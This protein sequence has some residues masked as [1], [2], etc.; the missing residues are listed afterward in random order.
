MTGAVPPLPHISSWPIQG[1]HS[2]I[3]FT[4]EVT[5]RLDSVFYSKETENLPRS[6]IVHNVLLLGQLGIE[7]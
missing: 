6:I 1:Q 7:M 3:Y 2:L 5:E 4:T